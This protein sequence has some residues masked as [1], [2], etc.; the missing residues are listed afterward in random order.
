M[1]ALIRGYPI[2]KTNSYNV[3]NGVKLLQ[4]TLACSTQSHATS[5]ALQAR[6]SPSAYL[7]TRP[8]S[9]LQ[10]VSH[11]SNPPF[12]R[13]CSPTAGTPSDP[14]QTSFTSSNASC[15]ASSPSS[16][17]NRYPVK[18][19]GPLH[20]VSLLSSGSTST[21]TSSRPSLAPPTMEPFVRLPRQRPWLSRPRASRRRRKVGTYANK[22]GYPGFL[23]FYHLIIDPKPNQKQSTLY[24]T[25]GRTS[26]STHYTRPIH[27]LASNSLIA[28]PP[29]LAS[30][31]GSVKFI[32]PLFTS[33]TQCMHPHPT[34]FFASFY[35]FCHHILRIQVNA[36]Y[37]LTQRSA[38]RFLHLHHTHSPSKRPPVFRLYQK[39]HALPKLDFPP[40][41][42][43]NPAISPT[44]LLLL[45]A[46]HPNQFH[47]SKNPM[48]SLPPTP[49][50][51]F[52]FDICVGHDSQM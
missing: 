49:A 8:L 39:S 47:K 31:I 27:S 43:H 50:L 5:A 7:P 52:M 45:F 17:S 29:T 11:S 26:I 32:P 37:I 46:Y 18:V 44:P 35:F 14:S 12:N 2:S 9:S 41:Y 28:L 15:P 20:V 6:P 21:A 3:S 36:L 10:T 38:I 30:L 19:L 22:K 24:S 34:L 48:P 23:N 13:P 42:Y 25:A 1:P 51:Y 4:T 33:S 16:W 40:F